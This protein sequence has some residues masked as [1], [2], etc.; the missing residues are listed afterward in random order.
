MM[1][2]GDAVEGILKCRGFRIEIEFR[3]R[4]FFNFFQTFVISSKSVII[5]DK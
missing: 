3:S 1:E 4:E 5:A 2:N